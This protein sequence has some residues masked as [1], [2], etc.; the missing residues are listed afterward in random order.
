M[1]LLSGCCVCGGVCV[2]VFL[3][4]FV[5]VDLR[6]DLR[7]AGI[8]VGLL[9]AFT[10]CVGFFL[11]VFGVCV[12]VVM[13]GSYCIGSLTASDQNVC[14]KVSNCSMPI[15]ELHIRQMGSKLSTVEAP[16]A[17]TDTT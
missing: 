5:R 15:S 9:V 14:L 8:R 16:P 17:N 10:V 2:R 13:C 6:I 12:C 7:V 3:D 11:R 1:L 4:V